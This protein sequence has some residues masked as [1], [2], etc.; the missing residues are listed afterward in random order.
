MP[1]AVASDLTPG[2]EP[3]FH[4]PLAMTLACLKQ[5]MTPQEALKGATT[6]AAQ[7]IA[8]QTRIGSLLPGFQADL[9]IIDAP[10]LNHWLYQFQANGC[11]AVMK[12][13]EWVW[14]ASPRISS[15]PE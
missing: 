10:S 12:R 2:S 11:H 1:V 13:G 15:D 3:S 6:I 8:A 4:L 7:A 14:P 5:G 9:A